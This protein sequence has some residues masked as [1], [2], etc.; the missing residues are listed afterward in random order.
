MDADPLKAVGR[1]NLSSRV[2]SE[3]RT[4]VMNGQ[5]APGDR[6]RFNDLAKQL[7]VSITPVRE[8]IFRLV[9]EQALEMKAATAVTVPV[10]TVK[11][12][13]EIR[14]I[15]HLL[16]GTA[17]ERA[18]E[19]ITD[20][21]LRELEDL[22][23]RFIA[24]AAVDPKLASR[25]NREFHFALM[26][27]AEMPYLYS[28]VE[29]LWAIMGPLF[30]IFHIRMPKRELLRNRHRHAKILNALRNRDGQAAR[31]AL[32]DDIAWGQPMIDWLEERERQP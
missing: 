19:L 26:S 27:V 18:A 16:E 1:E 28:I 23:E 12:L 7:G 11:Q 4:A 21:Q 10:I 22:Q 5:Y 17:A 2:Y 29:S 13:R 20:E 31:E 15:R 30:Q 32:Q 24:A 6:L 9:S 8:A 14:M 25:L 3:I